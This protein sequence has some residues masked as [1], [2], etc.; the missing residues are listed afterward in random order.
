MRFVC[1]RDTI[2]H[3]PELLQLHRKLALP[4]LIIR[5][6]LKM[7]CQ[8]DRLHDPD[9][10]LGGV[11]LVPFDRVAVIHGELVVEVVITFTNRDESSDHVVTRSV[12][13]I[14]WRVTKPVSE[15]VHTE[16]GL[17]E[18][19]VNKRRWSRRAHM[20]YVVNEA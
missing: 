18:R 14:E 9:E 20:T 10:P 6:G 15:G 4:N 13:V 7:A 8:T 19:D 16:G 2:L 5:E 1:P 3:F 12:L 11:I 17:S